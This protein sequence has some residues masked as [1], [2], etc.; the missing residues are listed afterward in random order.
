MY[1]MRLKL[2]ICTAYSVV[3]IFLC[4]LDSLY[5]FVTNS[6]LYA[7]VYHILIILEFKNS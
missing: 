7:I 1:Q 6:I 2:K 4:I 5:F 3:Q